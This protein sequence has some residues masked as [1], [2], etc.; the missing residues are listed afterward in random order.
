MHQIVETLAHIAAQVHRALA[1]HLQLARQQ[2]DQ[3][4]E[5]RQLRLEVH[6]ARRV[7]W[8]RTESAE[9]LLGCELIFSERAGLVWAILGCCLAPQASYQAGNQ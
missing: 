1:L 3:L 5:L 4:V 9:I 6:V 7:D 2:L 8:S